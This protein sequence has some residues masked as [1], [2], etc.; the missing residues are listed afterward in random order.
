[1]V[2]TQASVDDPVR[3]RQSNLLGTAQAIEAPQVDVDAINVGM[4]KATTQQMLRALAEVLGELSPVRHSPAPSGDIRH[5]RANNQRLL[6]RFEM[7]EATATSVGLARL[8]GR[9]AC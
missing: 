2:S 5:S 8:P 3:T 9:E 6:E 7:A 1:M 4:N